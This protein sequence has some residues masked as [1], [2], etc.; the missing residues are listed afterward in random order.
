M[1]E[2]PMVGFRR[3][4]RARPCSPSKDLAPIRVDS[5]TDEYPMRESAEIV[6]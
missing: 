6:G 3:R 1:I 4:L 2:K 5:A